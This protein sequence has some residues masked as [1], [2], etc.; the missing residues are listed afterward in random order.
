MR[1]LTQDQKDQAVENKRIL[2]E[3]Q[4][5]KCYYCDIHFERDNVIPHAAHIII[6]SVVNIRKYGYEILDNI[7]NFKITC[8][9]CNP[10]AIITNPES[11]T[12]IDHIEAIR[13]EIEL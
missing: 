5:G 7:K 13:K 3:R 2:G 10:K 6:D 4:G 12:G 9:N 1:K 8:P 11:Q